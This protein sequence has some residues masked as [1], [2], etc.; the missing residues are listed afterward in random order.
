MD[1]EVV[2]NVILT[3]E[4]DDEKIQWK[5]KD[6]KDRETSLDTIKQYDSDIKEGDSDQ[7]KKLACTMT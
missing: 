5:D 4:Q 1:R 7:N 6:G 2:D 3:L